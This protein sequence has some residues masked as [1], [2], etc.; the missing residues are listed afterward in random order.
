V[1]PVDFIEA[2][3]A[4]NGGSSEQIQSVSAYKGEDVDGDPFTLTAWK[5]TKED[6]E[7]LMNDGALYVK[8]YGTTPQPMILFT[9]NNNNEPNLKSTV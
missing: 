4:L 9:T 2:N 1:I 6:L 8:A 5:P 3:P 7:N